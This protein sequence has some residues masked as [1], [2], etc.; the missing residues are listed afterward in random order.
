MAYMY[1]ID[2]KNIN[3]NKI[4]LYLNEFNAKRVFWIYNN[5]PECVRGRHRH[6][7]STH[8]LHCIEG[9]C[10]VRVNNG[11]QESTFVLEN[12][13]ELLYLAPSDWREMY[14]FSENCVLMCIS[15]QFYDTVDYINIPYISES[16]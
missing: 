5:S 10:K 13:N 7:K 8:V 6:K 15:N 2:S 11:F 9:S 4:E 12:N 14:D 1:V 3:Q 16:K